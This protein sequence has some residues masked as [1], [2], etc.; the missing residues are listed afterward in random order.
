MGGLGLTGTS[1]QPGPAPVS[2]V[3][4]LI[5]GPS[6]VVPDLMFPIHLLPTLSLS[7]SLSLSL[8]T[9]MVFQGNNIFE[10]HNVKVGLRMKSNDMQPT[11]FRLLLCFFPTIIDFQHDEI[12]VRDDQKELFLLREI[13]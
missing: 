4:K 6:C 11:P 7:P 8:L 2:G 13:Q 5:A 9:I 3:V 1:H 10:H 12:H